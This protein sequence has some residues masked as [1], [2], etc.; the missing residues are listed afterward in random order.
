MGK[1]KHDEHGR[2]NLGG[3]IGGKGIFHE[4]SSNED[5]REEG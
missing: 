3:C 5:T 1:G 2:W 4:A